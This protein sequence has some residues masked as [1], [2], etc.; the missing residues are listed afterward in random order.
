MR[1][2]FVTQYFPPETGAAPARALHFARALER[3][4][5][6]VRVVTGIPNHPSGVVQPAYARVRRAHERLGGI[7][8]ERVWLYA[9]PRRTPATRLANHLSFAGSALG[10]ALT[11]PP[12]DVVLASMPPLFLGVTALLAAWRHHAPLVLDC[13][14]DWPWTAVSLGELREGFTVRMLERLTLFLQRRAARVIAVNPAMQRAFQ[15]HGVDEGRL[16][17]CTNG[18]DTDLFRP[19]APVD[20]CADGDAGGRPLTV[21]YAGTHGLIHGMEALLDAAERLRERQDLRFVFIGDGVAKES[22]Q[23]R[24]RESG[25]TRVEFLPSMAPERLVEQ[26]QAAGICVATMRD[27]PQCAEAVPVKLYDYLACG[28]PVVAAVAGDAARLIEA[29]GAGLVV[30]PEDGAALA[31]A[32]VALSADPVRRAA[33][34]ASGP[35]FIEAGYSRRASGDR[36][37][38][39]LQEVHRRARGREVAPLPAGLGGAAK[40]LVDVLVAGALLVLLAPLLVVIALAIRM[41]SPGPALFRQRR[42]GRGSRE[43]TILKFRTMQVGTP[44]LASHLMGPGSAQVTRVGRVLRRTSLDELPQFFNV[45]AGHMTLVGPR[46]ALHNQDDLIALRQQAGV[47]ALKPGV[48]GWAQIHGRDDIPLDLKLEYDRWYLARAS[49]LLDLWI[50][51]RTPFALLSPRGV[52]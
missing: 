29:S 48:T 2:L 19:A 15:S 21:L 17:L 31:G 13:R 22:L 6:E 39:T 42:I 36:L 7:A 23:Q 47:D 11:G 35:R 10:P 20:R 18:A 32:L 45:L 43:F 12:P 26:I 37:A 52:F 40:R 14:D 16:V 5:H 28:R 34:A 3:A 51:L 9:T 8:V 25:L 41:D 24:A 27:H 46:P 33:L 4:G 1:V 38:E 49:F 30:P 44:D 50:V